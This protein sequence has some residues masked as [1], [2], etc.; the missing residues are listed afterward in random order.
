MKQEKNYNFNTL[1]STLEYCRDYNLL[2]NN[3][4]INN[5]TEEKL[6]KIIIKKNIHKLKKK[7]N[8]YI[9]NKIALHLLIRCINEQK[10]NEKKIKNRININ[11]NYINELLNN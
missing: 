5:F 9:K 1:T 4:N 11:E 6:Q 7:K 2:D 8:M 10:E 3:K